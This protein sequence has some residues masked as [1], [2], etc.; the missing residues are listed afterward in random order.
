[1]CTALLSPLGAS[2]HAELVALRVDERRRGRPAA[3]IA[4]GWAPRARRS[5]RTNFQMSSSQPGGAVEPAR[6][7]VGPVADLGADQPRPT[8]PRVPPAGRCRCTRRRPARAIRRRAA[9]SRNAQNSLP[10]TSASVTHA[11]MFGQ[12]PGA[13]IRAAARC[14]ARR[15]PDARGSSRSWAARCG[16]KDRSARCAGTPSAAAQNASAAAGSTASTT[17]GPSR[18]AAR[19]PSLGST[20]ADRDATWPGAASPAPRVPG[21][22]RGWP[23]ALRTAG[24]RFTI[25]PINADSRT[26]DRTR[27]PAERREPGERRRQVVGPVDEPGQ[28]RGVLEALA[29]ALAQMRPHRV[30]GVAD[31]QHRSTR[32]LPGLIAVVE[33][34]AQ[35]VV[36][37]RR[38]QHRGDGFGP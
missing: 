17:S 5:T 10:S 21:R 11:E 35:H 24:R 27:G 33:V 22:W 9:G 15:R 13:Q 38:G 14:R 8:T 16:R 12:H 30:G 36:G 3:S 28:D 26:S 37:V 23:S 6:R 29:A 7:A 25:R 1:M 32:P 34:V 19:R 2:D 20:N 18:H 31:D 4:S